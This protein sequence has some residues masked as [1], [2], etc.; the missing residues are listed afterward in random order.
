VTAD[1]V[2]TK[3]TNLVSLAGVD[4]IWDVPWNFGE[5]TIDSSIHL[6][7]DGV[8]FFSMTCDGVGRFYLCVS[9]VFPW[10]WES[11]IDCLHEHKFV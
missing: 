6:D 8:N 9:V 5:M 11:W 10:N 1:V 3:E 4:V 7:D 2:D